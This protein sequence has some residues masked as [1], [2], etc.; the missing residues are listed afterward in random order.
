[1]TRPQYV[2]LLLRLEGA[3]GAVGL[4]TQVGRGRST[5]TE[6]TAKE[7]LNERVEDNLGAAGLRKSH[8]EDEGEL[9]GVVEC[10]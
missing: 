6:V 10:C 4:S 1:M 5:T 7:R 2:F 3:R 8:P 9:E